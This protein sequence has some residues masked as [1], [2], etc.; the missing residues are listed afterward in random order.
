M[1]AGRADRTE[2][3]LCASKQ[4]WPCDTIAALDLNA[5]QR[6][7]ADR[8]EDALGGADW[9]TE[10]LT[11]AR[12]FGAQH[13]RERLLAVAA[14]E[15]EANPHHSWPF[16]ECFWGDCLHAHRLLADPEAKP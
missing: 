6:E 2:C 9:Y 4:D 3:F 7:R 8:A 5:E 1:G 13:E 12:D 15:H 11:I 14:S 10:A 16:D